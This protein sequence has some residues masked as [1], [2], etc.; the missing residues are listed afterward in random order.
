M[1]PR[2]QDLPLSDKPGWPWTEETPPLPLTKPDGTD[3]PKIS[4]ITPS[5][6]QARYL[7]E[8]IRSVLLQGY[9]N[10]EYI[11]I[12]GGSTDE[13]VDIIK[14]YEPWLSYWVSEK[15]RGQSQAINKGFAKA[16]GDIFAWINSDDYYAPG[17]FARVADAFLQHD[18][19]W[20]AGI[21]CRVH[22]DGEIFK[23]SRKPPKKLE[24][25]YVGGQYQQQGTFWR[26]NLWEFA[27]G[28]DETLHFAF[29]YDLWMKFIKVQPFAFWIDQPLANFRIHPESKTS[30][31]Q[32]KFM[33]ERQIVYN[34]NRFKSGNPSSH[35]FIWRRRRE[36]K[37][38]IY[39]S[40]DDKE[41][42]VFN[43]LWLALWNAPWLLFNRS[44]LYGIYKMVVKRQVGD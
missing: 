17:A 14:K 7:E 33:K 5:Y 2:L 25:W 15:D 4:I 27:G 12:D 18:T 26:R 11:I 22:P 37:A 28:V 13:S 20:V 1:I 30:L 39:L 29:D 32:L 9:P 31:D 43:K 16:T 10:L 42:P 24:I 6:N 8:T 35:F 21:T 19:Q 3:W 40:V 34:R 38:R 44:F 41:L 23:L 36:R